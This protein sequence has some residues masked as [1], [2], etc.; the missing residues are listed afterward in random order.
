MGLCIDDELFPY[1][2]RFPGNSGC[3]RFIPGKPAH[4]IHG[5]PTPSEQLA[6]KEIRPGQIKILEVVEAVNSGAMGYLV[7]QTSAD[8][9]C[10]AI[11]EVQK[12]NTFFSPSIPKHLHKW[13]GK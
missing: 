1:K 10:Q 11:R 8:T 13:N 7:K 5:R 6:S 9:G 3:N 4:A 12:G 2:L